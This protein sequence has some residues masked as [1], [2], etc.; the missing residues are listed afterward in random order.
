MPLGAWRKAE[1][2]RRKA[3]GGRRKAESSF[4]TV[5]HIGLQ[6]VMRRALDQQRT[7]LPQLS[8]ARLDRLQIPPNWY[9]WLADKVTDQLPEETV[10]QAYLLAFVFCA[11]QYLFEVTI[12]GG[13]FI[14]T[15][16][17]LQ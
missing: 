9:L 15:L 16:G 11:D 2:G 17:R 1:G 5:A 8:I 7:Q 4:N 14:Q 3:E 13:W 12:A 10:V 6:E